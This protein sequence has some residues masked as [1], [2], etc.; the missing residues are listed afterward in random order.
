MAE[1]G[2]MMRER[3]GR[4]WG[5]ALALALLG[6]AGAAAAAEQE[7]EAGAGTQPAPVAEY[8][9][10]AG[11]ELDIVLPLNPEFNVRTF[12][13][14]DGKISLEL[15]DEITAEGLTTAELTEH[16]RNA[17]STELRD[18]DISVN[19]VSMAARI[20]VDGHVER[21]GEYP[22]SRQVT[23]MQA[24]ALAG[25]LRET[26]QGKSLLVVR[27][28]AG[29]EQR[30]FQIDLEELAAGAGDSRDLYLAPYD[31]VYVPASR[32][33]DVNKWMTQYIKD[34]IPVSPRRM[35]PG[36]VLE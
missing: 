4:Y 13:R 2:A 24:V 36:A 20:Y 6:A 19:V 17:Y 12:V 11:D 31:T 3:R 5:L 9:I 28:S 32:V 8:R 30:V 21:P 23:A 7:T 25:G 16:L 18:P 26:A 10:A 15:V 1:T 34:N 33:A 22:W 29:G 14:P 27:R 35:V